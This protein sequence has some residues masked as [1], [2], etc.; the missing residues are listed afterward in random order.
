MRCLLVVLCAFSLVA[1][2]KA[3]P[4]IGSW[5]TSTDGVT[6][7]TGTTRLTF[8]DGGKLT[9]ETKLSGKNGLS[10]TATDTGTWKLEADKMTVHIDDTGW[11]FAGPGADKAD[12]KFKENRDK[13]LANANEN[14]TETIAWTNNDEF[15]L[16][17]P[18]GTKKPY[19]R[20][21]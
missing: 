18:K 5:E 17:D 19:R 3:S 14:P 21:K 20:V 6:G 13:V 7:A 9:A 16:T 15:T 8:A 1:C 12:A 11:K 2:Q 10:L 4:L